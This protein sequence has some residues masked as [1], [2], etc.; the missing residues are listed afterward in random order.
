MPEKISAITK[1]RKAK[2]KRY[3]IKVF[4]A[5]F[6]RVCR[7]NLFKG[8]GVVRVV[9]FSHSPV[10]T[11]YLLAYIEALKSCGRLDV[12]VDIVFFFMDSKARKRETNRCRV[13]GL[14][15]RKEWFVA[16]KRYDLCVV[17][18]HSYPQYLLNDFTPVLFIYHGLASVKLING[19]SYK[20]GSRYVRD[21][22]GRFKYDCMFEA[23]KMQAQ[24]ACSI[25]TE[26]ASVVKVVG[27]PF[28][29]EFLARCVYRSSIRE[30]LG[31]SGSDRV[32]MLQSTW[33]E[34]SLDQA[35]GSELFPVCHRLAEEGK[36][37][38]VLSTHPNNWGGS[39]IATDRKD[40]YLG[41]QRDGFRVLH[42]E[43]DR[44]DFLAASDLCLSDITSLSILY[45]FS[46]RPL[47]FVSQS[48]V[49][50]DSDCELARLKALCPQA[51]RAVEIED[52][53]NCLEMTYPA[54]AVNELM[55]DI[56]DY[57]GE[58]ASRCYE[59]TVRLLGRS[60]CEV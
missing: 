31:F 1:I 14:L 55:A 9:M 22:F 37:K 42:P 60:M 52:F 12:E 45:A 58:Y 24:I 8:K 7:P 18:D 10:M 26:F 43:E 57:Q 28:V 35:Y 11:N 33:D 20:Y 23:G 41:L 46:G 39:R 48:E 50:I 16:G 4:F 30:R 29:D 32:V 15:V 17:A 5:E 53:L 34:K 44:L 13:Q 2:G 40:Y 38:F 49:E 36:F 47:G 3:S 54:E 6:L 27:D 59:E 19:Q 51:R 25:A 56:C 21:V